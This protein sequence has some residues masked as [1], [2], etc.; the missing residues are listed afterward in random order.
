MY[1][2]VT[3]LPLIESFGWADRSM[4]VFYLW[5]SCSTNY[6]RHSCRLTASSSVTE[7]DLWH[8]RKT[9]DIYYIFNSTVTTAILY[10]FYKDFMTPGILKTLVKTNAFNRNLYDLWSCTLL[11]HMTKVSYQSR[12]QRHS[13]N[14]IKYENDWLACNWIDERSA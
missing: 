4:L 12:H 14:W 1:C 3:K 6:L 9:F 2:T 10:T 11:C 5:E 7:T 13:M 8:A